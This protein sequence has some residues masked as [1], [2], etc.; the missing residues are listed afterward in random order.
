MKIPYTRRRRLLW[1]DCDPAGVIYTPNVIHLGLEIIEHWLVELIGHDCIALQN[2][3]GL[4]TPTVRL[5]C[6]FTH[7]VRAG[8]EVELR[9]RIKKLGSSSIN[10]IVE[11]FNEADQLCFAIDQV[12]CFVGVDEFKPVQIPDEFREKIAAYCTACDEFAEKED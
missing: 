7:A 6:E 1:G 2:K 10:Y 12:S 8:D 4:D 5:N 3:Y 9:L 11:G